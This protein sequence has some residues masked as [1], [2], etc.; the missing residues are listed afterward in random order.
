[1][2]QNLALDDPALFTAKLNEIMHGEEVQVGR[3]VPIVW[4]KVSSR[5]PSADQV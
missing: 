5:R 1:M 4:K 3:L 2:E